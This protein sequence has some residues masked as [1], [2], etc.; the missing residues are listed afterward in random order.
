MEVN[1]R[2]LESQEEILHIKDQYKMEL[3]TSE[4][5]VELNA[6]KRESEFEWYLMLLGLIAVSIIIFG[7][8]RFLLK[9]RS[10]Q[11]CL[12]EIEKHSEI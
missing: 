9:K 12:S 10:I 6:S 4:F 8:S 11:K 2:F 3:L 5:F 1:K 7:R